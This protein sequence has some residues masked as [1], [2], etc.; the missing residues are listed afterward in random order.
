MNGLRP[1]LKSWVDNTTQPPYNKG[2]FL[3]TMTV[4]EVQKEVE[5][6]TIE[7]IRKYPCS[8]SQRDDFYCMHN[9]FGVAAARQIMIPPIYRG[10]L[11]LPSEVVNA[12]QS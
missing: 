10:E 1:L 11:P 5:L 7:N 3:L 9:K 4:E 2:G 12:T 6:L 8:L